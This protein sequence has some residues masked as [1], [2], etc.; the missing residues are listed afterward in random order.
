MQIVHTQASKN[1]ENRTEFS[2]FIKLKAIR[3]QHDFMKMLKNC[4]NLA[5]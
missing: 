3:I 5:L 2:A 4:I 1:L